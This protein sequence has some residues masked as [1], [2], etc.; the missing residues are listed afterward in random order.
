[1]KNNGCESR[2]GI[3][4]KVPFDFIDM[5]TGRSV[6]GEFGCV[7]YDIRERLKTTV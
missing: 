5:N 6:I 7:M 2:A 3:I 4:H 1:M